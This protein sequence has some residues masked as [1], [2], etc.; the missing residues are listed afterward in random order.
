MRCLTVVA[1]SSVC[2]W[3]HAGGLAVPVEAELVLVIQIWK[4]LDL[5]ESVAGQ[6]GLLT[7]VAEALA[8]VA[9]LS[10]LGHRIPPR[11]AERQHRG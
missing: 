2:G 8:V 11:V 4:R 9:H 5:R 3:W 7:A 6:V 10:W 1:L